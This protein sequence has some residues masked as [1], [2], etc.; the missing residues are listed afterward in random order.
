LITRDLEKGDAADGGGQNRA[1][2]LDD[3]GRENPRVQQSPAFV[4][5]SDTQLSAWP[6]CSFGHGVGDQ[7]THRRFEPWI[8]AESFN[9][10]EQ[11]I[12]VGSDGCVTI[13]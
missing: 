10:K 11:P 12:R 4:Q 8:I 13:E 6:G 9:V 7:H 2:E 3:F 5:Q 1:E